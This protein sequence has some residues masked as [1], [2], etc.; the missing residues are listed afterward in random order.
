MRRQRYILQPQ[1]IHTEN[2]FMQHNAGQK[3]AT[4]LSTGM[5]GQ[6]LVLF[7]TQHA[8]SSSTRDMLRHPC[9]A[10]G[11]TLCVHMQADSCTQRLMLLL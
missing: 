8:G 4:A 11:R 9:H 1:E 10:D 3:Q 2:A 6:G 7:H 5:T